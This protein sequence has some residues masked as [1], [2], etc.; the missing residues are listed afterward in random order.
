MKKIRKDNKGNILK[1]GISQRPDGRYYVKVTSNGK[2]KTKYFDDLAEAER[3]N[4][5]IRAQ[6]KQGKSLDAATVTVKDYFELWI[7]RLDAILKPRTISSYQS[8]HKC[9]ILPVIG[10][11]HMADVTPSDC[12][13]VLS[14]M[15][16]S[17]KASTIDKVRRV[18]KLMFAAAV[19]EGIIAKSPVTKSVRTP[20]DATGKPKRNHR[21][22]CLAPEEERVF[23]DAA[24]STNFYYQY[25][26][27]LYTGLRVSELIGLKWED[28]DLDNGTIYIQRSLSY[29]KG[30]LFASTK[31]ED[32]TRSF[33]LSQKARQILTELREGPSNVRTDTPKEFQ[34]LVF[35]N[36]KGLPTQAGTYDA[37]LKS[38]CRK[39]GI[40][41]ISM[42]CLRHMF[43]TH[44]VD[45]GIEY[46]VLSVIMG[47]KN[48]QTTLNLYVHATDEKQRIEINKIDEYLA[49][50]A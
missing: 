25:M 35:L 5:E 33:P 29:N 49:M 32:G 7:S 3:W 1:R 46:K 13:R 11:M 36:R 41:H 14:G 19:E 48:I 9:H 24:K 40:S 23:V 39:A 17:H 2:P 12:Q 15:R 50:A 38:L 22:F 10:K 16:D 27:A 8:N 34:D 6:L 18:T 37:N 44:A 21:V 42:H 45:A 4:D 20:K 28:V 26:L 30:W 43:A 47:H 31:T